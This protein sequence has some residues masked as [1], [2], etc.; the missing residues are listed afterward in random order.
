MGLIQFAQRLTRQPSTASGVDWNNP[1]TRGLTF[2]TSMATQRDLVTNRI[3]SRSGATPSP[4]VGGLGIKFSGANA[5]DN[6]G[7]TRV[8]PGGSTTHTVLSAGI[9]LATGRGH[10]FSQGLQTGNYPQSTIAYGIDNSGGASAGRITFLEFG[11]GGS[12][13]ASA[14]ANTVIGH[15][16]GKYHVAV[17]VRNGAA[18][19]TRIYVDGVNAT[20][21]T[22]GNGNVINASTQTVSIGNDAGYAGTDREAEGGVVAAAVWNRVLSD[23]EI[24]SAS[25]NPWQLF[26]PR[27]IWVPVS[28]GGG[29]TPVS[30]DRSLSW[31]VRS[32]VQAGQSLAY[33]VKNAAQQSQ[34]LAWA[35]RQSANQTLPLTYTLRSGVSANAPIA[36]TVKNA[37]QQSQPLAWTLRAGVQA[38]RALSWALLNAAQSNRSLS[39]TLRSGV[40]ANA[41][42]AYTVSASIQRQLDLAWSVLNSGTVVSTLPLTWLVRAGVLSSRSLAWALRSGVQRTHDLAWVI[43]NSGTVTSQRS[44]SWLVRSA[45]QQPQTLAYPVRNAVQANR[46]I[47]Y[48]VLTAAQSNLLIDYLVRAGVQVSFPLSYGV[49][50]TVQNQLPLA[51]V[52]F[53]SGGVPELLCVNV[54]SAFPFSAQI[55]S[56]FP[57]LRVALKNVTTLSGDC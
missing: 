30:S 20:E 45:V 19:N 52:V 49:S 3:A 43:L 51:W 37:A 27:R 28:A 35:V 39:Y 10:L 46:T 50:G 48:P 17:G 6:Y 1:I 34:P 54:E 40:S 47:A 13:T 44:L 12:S 15:A 23:A 33:P 14:G 55:D 53:S 7:Q 24:Y 36:Y 42:I 16:D 11:G 5:R 29:T 38:S 57:D 41:P 26:A 18:E 2:L 4:T 9:F 32:G 21:S 31:L 56:G 25:L 8:I 22:A